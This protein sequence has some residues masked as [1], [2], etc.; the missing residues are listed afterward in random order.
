M[1]AGAAAHRAG[2][3]GEEP[4][5]PRAGFAWTL[6]WV[7]GARLA[8]LGCSLLGSLIVFRAL[9]KADPSLADSGRFAIAMAT[10]RFLTNSIGGAADLSVLRSVP[11]LRLSDR[12]AA[13]NVVR[14]AFLMRI[15]AVLAV[16]LIAAAGRSWFGER[17]LGGAEHS[18]LLL[19]IVA[20]AAAE[21]LLRAVLAY[22]QA[23]ERFGR[24]VAFEALFQAGRLAAI[25]ALAAAGILSVGAVLAAYAA[26]GLAAALCGATRL[27]RE[28]FRPVLDRAVA[29]EV[30][31]FFSWT[32]LALALSAGNERVDL[33]LLGRF[34]GAEEA[35]L[36]G[37]ILSIAVV[38]DFLGGLLVT[39]LQPRIV[40]LHRRG[41][42][43]AFWGRLMLAMAPCALFAGALVAV[44]GSWFVGVALG[45]R[46][47][48]GAPAFVVLA[49]G[50]LVW[51]AMVPVPGALITLS[52]PRVT[53]ALTTAQLAMVAGGCFLAIPR[54]GLFGA[55]LTV[56]CMRVAVAVTTVAIGWRMTSARRRASARPEGVAAPP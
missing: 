4:A 37:G 1:R 43:R 8:M 12:A 47:E 33:F 51:L 28:L 31:R 40:N 53:T 25:L 44:A 22:F 3:G 10:I 35:G 18:R 27:P 50:S 41:E 38:P 54:L 34:A 36:Y 19:L 42:L 56:A 6:F 16:V 11:V 52:A 45:A 14:A 48:A 2:G 39:V 17:F 24:F 13:A 55:A 21:L 15:A 30:L 26:L 29:A 7:S 23:V 20:A 9:A 5:E 46:Y 49:L 32:L